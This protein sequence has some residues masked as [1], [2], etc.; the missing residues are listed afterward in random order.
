MMTGLNHVGLFVKD[1]QVSKAFYTE[2]LGF[3]VTCEATMDD[4]TKVCFVRLNDLT[5]EIV[6]F[7]EY[8]QKCDGYF[9]HIAFMVDDIEATM[10][11]LAAKGIAFETEEPV[12][13]PVFEKG[14]RYVM[15]RG[16]DGEHL[17]ITETH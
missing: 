10:Q 8:S 3:E 2:T 6:Q 15:F 5:I 17:Q 1:V 4:G 16:P 12:F 7:P 13:M 14:V 9:D 11:E